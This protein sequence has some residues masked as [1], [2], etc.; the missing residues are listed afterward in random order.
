MWSDKAF[1]MKGKGY[2]VFYRH[3]DATLDIIM[4]KRGVRKSRNLSK[5]RDIGKIK[6][7]IWTSIIKT[8]I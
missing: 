4:L 3:L 1:T 7:K 6:T 8:W 5:D 2:V